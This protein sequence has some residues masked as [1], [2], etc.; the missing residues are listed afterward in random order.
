M[1]IQKIIQ[2][3]LLTVLVNIS[4]CASIPKEAV[5]LNQTVAAGIKSIHESN[6]RFV[7][8]Y[9]ELKQAEIKRYESDAINDFFSKVAGASSVDGAPPLKAKDLFRIKQK[10]E[11]I[12]AIGSKYRM[13][14]TLSKSKI[15]EKL[16]SE[17][18]SLIMVNGS[19][20]GLLE[21]AVDTDDAVQDGLLKVKEYSNG[22]IDLTDIDAKVDEFLS[23]IGN[24]AGKANS[25][26][27][28][29]KEI[30]ESSEGD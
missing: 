9:F 19:I 23:T 6:I 15:I 14:L 1:Y 12:Y 22:K 26:V 20:T 27:N 28:S 2:A 17:Y 3:L 25:L 13:E 24:K 16:Q 8:Q 5:T 11:D 7:E 30:I 4:G 29:I 18:N 21:S 10:V